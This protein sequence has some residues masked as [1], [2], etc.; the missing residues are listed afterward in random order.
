[1]TILLFILCPGI[2]LICYICSAIILVG[3]LI[4]SPFFIVAEYL[5]YK[6]E[7]SKVNKGELK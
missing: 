5:H 2:L 4:M 7:K 6:K 1:M 3:M